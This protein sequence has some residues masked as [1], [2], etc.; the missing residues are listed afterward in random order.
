MHKLFIVDKYLCLVHPTLKYSDHQNPP[1]YGSIIIP[2]NH[3]YSKNGPITPATHIHTQANIHDVDGGRVEM[4]VT[5]S[6]LRCC[7]ASWTRSKRI[8]ASAAYRCATNLTDKRTQKV[9]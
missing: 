2:N 1:N 7:K 9:T 4:S 8:K 5:L 3:E 6:G